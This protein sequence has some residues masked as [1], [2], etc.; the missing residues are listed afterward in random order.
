MNPGPLVWEFSTLFTRLFS[1]NHFQKTEIFQISYEFPALKI[2]QNFDKLLLTQ[3]N[4][5]KTRCFLYTVILLFPSNH[6]CTLQM[7]HEILNAFYDK[8]SFRVR[9]S[10][11][12]NI[13]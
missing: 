10:P 13:I 11:I 5:K 4:H 2:Y 6:I 7:I 3:K 12:L 9:R 8:K 1:D